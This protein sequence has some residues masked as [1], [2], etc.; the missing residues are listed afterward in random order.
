MPQGSG[1][2]GRHGIALPCR[3][4]PAALMPA[5][6]SLGGLQSKV[7]LACPC[8]S[9]PATCLRGCD[10][11]GRLAAVARI[12]RGASLAAA[13]ASG[14]GSCFPCYRK[15]LVAAADRASRA[16]AG[17]RPVKVRFGCVSG[18]VSA[19]FPTAVFRD[20][21]RLRRPGSGRVGSGSSRAGPR[22][23]GLGPRSGSASLAGGPCD[24]HVSG[25]GA[26]S[27]SCGASS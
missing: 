5:R 3:E 4:S 23:A 14:P 20:S 26:L 2:R 22:R 10:S 11:A 25:H 21:L 24:A 15:V 9:A 1:R 7:A 13:R 19:A 16:W 6:D 18:C 8:A 27:D 12:S 17:K